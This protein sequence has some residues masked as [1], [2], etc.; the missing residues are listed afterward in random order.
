MEARGMSCFS[1]T[2]TYNAPLQGTFSALLGTTTKFKLLQ[3]VNMAVTRKLSAK[4]LIYTM[5]AA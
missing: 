1:R 4:L 3:L 2:P 5:R